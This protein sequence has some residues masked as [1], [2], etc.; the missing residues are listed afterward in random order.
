MF[1]PFEILKNSKNKKVLMRE[2]SVDK[3]SLPPS[4]LLSC[5]H[6]V[7]GTLQV[8]RLVVGVFSSPLYH[9]SSLCMTGYSMWLMVRCSIQIPQTHQSQMMKALMDCV[10]IIS[11]N[12]A[13]CHFSAIKELYNLS[14]IKSFPWPTAL[15][16]F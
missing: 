3:Y 4:S 7:S 13:F 9:P 5:S 8:L 11:C 10:W 2:M 6:M 12:I 16:C 1:G 14:I 15:C